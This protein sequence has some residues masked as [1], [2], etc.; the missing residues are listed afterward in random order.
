M[1]SIHSDDDLSDTTPPSDRLPPDKAFAALGNELRIAILQTVWEAPDHELQFSEIKDRTGIADKGQLRYHLNR[2]TDHFLHH[3]S[4]GTYS[5]SEAGKQV[6]RA[7]LAGSVTD[8]PTRDP[9]EV[10][11]P[12]LLCDAPLEIGY[13]GEHLTISCIKCDGLTPG[14]YPSGIISMYYPPAGLRNRDSDDL[15]E[16]AFTWYWSRVTPMVEGLCPHCAGTTQLNLHICDD[17]VVDNGLV[18]DH[19]TTPYMVWTEYV[20][21]NCAYCRSMPLAIH[22]VLNA[23]AIAFYNDHDIT[24]EMLKSDFRLLADFDEAVVSR[25]PLRFMARIAID[26]DELTLLFDDSATI[27]E[28][29]RSTTG[30]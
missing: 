26:T 8:N 1:V 18:C 13:A 14:D 15:L 23:D 22:F 24:R 10:D 30:K 11:R 16:A 20:C 21:T 5:L 17:H 25:D 27:I 29:K 12:C 4:E 28:T 9:V 6:V 7:V 2:L 19:C 3:A